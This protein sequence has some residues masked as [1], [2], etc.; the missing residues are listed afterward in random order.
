MN[1]TV[2]VEVVKASN[3]DIGLCAASPPHLLVNVVDPG[4][5]TI[6]IATPTALLYAGYPSHSLPD[7][8]HLLHCGLVSSHFTLRI[9]LRED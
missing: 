8:I 3:R 1:L 5:G 2:V 7:R 6:G 4:R 9:L